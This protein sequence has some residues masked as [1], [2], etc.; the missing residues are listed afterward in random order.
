VSNVGVLYELASLPY[1]L[2]ITLV[3]F[4]SA[5][6]GAPHFTSKTIIALFPFRDLH[7]ANKQDG[8]MCS[9]S[10]AEG[11][12]GPCHLANEPRVLHF[13]AAAVAPLVSIQ[14]NIMRSTEIKLIQMLKDN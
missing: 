5:P 10:L 1:P 14:H 4:W 2:I 9:L 3:S 11:Y 12:S 6:C 13:V 8:A 7:D